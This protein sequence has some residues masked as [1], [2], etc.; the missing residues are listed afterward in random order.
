MYSH[1]R[2]ILHK[3]LALR[4]RNSKY[5]EN[6]IRFRLWIYSVKQWILKGGGLQKQGEHHKD[7]SAVQTKNTKACILN[8]GVLQ[9]DLEQVTIAKQVQIKD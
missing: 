9:D 7:K 8:K 3:M 5:A 1:Q 6:V 4:S 2:Y